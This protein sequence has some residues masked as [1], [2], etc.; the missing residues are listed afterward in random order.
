M[1][2]ALGGTAMIGPQTRPIQRPARVPG[3]VA[4]TAKLVASASAV[5][6]SAMPRV[7]VMAVARPGVASA[8]RIGCHD[9]PVP[10]SAGKNP[11]AGRITPMQLA[12]SG[13]TRSP[14]SAA[15]ATWCQLP[16]RMPGLAAAAVT[17]TP[18]GFDGGH[19]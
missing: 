5:V 16:V 9:S 4:S 10:P 13:R 7:R 17:L 12:A 19:P 3:N 18:S 1:A 15:S 8:S 6:A 11:T 2:I 14:R